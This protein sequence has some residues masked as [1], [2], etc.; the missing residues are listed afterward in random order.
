MEIWERG[1]KPII[2]LVIFILIR[3][4]IL[5]C[6]ILYILFKLVTCFMGILQSCGQS[7]I[8]EHDGIR[9]SGGYFFRNAGFFSFKDISEV[10]TSSSALFDFFNI[11]YVIVHSRVPNRAPVTLYK[12]TLRPQLIWIRNY[13]SLSIALTEGSKK[14]NYCFSTKNT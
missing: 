7:Y 2:S 11:G 6:S 8:I 10:K 9:I 12:S 5:I 4:C 13:H 14:N 3:G 1:F